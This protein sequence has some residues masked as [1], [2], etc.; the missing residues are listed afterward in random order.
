MKTISEKVNEIKTA[1]NFNDTL[2]AFNAACE[3]C[4]WNAKCSRKCPM[5]R[6]FERKGNWYGE[7][8]P[9]IMEVVKAELA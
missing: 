9:A 2:K 6:E 3:N 5:Y 1:R 4:I 7:K 8:D